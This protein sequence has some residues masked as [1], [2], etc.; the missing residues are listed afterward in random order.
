MAKV[1]G[2]RQGKQLGGQ[3]MSAGSPAEGLGRRKA[4]LPLGKERGLSSDLTPAARRILDAARRL[5]HEQGYRGLTFDAIA[6]ESGANKSMIR[7][8]FG[9]K[10]GLVAALLDDLTHDSA[11]GFLEIARKSQGTDESLAAHFEA[12]R[13]LVADPHFVNL[14]DILPKALRRPSLRESVASLYNWYRE[15]EA[16][17]LC[18]SQPD[19]DSD[20]LALASLYIAFI[21]GLALQ[22][23]ISQEDVDLDRCWR[24]IESM[25]KAHLS[26]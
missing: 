19:D 17:C 3:T 24:L 26:A 9:S 23:A 15:I 10:E 12:S 11:V 8:Y 20:L 25:I 7:Y 4:S 13:R 21:D 1:S 18:Q 2:A 6:E 14:F 16:Y 5:L 22:W